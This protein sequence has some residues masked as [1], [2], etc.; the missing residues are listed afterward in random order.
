MFVKVD[1]IMH[2]LL[3]MDCDSYDCVSGAKTSRKLLMRMKQNKRQ[4]ASKT[5]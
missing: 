2:Y 1:D 3:P 5:F 4:C